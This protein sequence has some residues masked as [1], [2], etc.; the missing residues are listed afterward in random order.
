[1]RWLLVGAP[2]ARADHL[3]GCLGPHDRLRALP[4]VELAAALADEPDVVLIDAGRD[5][6]AA[7]AA[8]ALARR[9]PHPPLVALVVDP[10]DH[11]AL[12]AALG[13]GVVT[14]VAW[15]PGP[16]AMEQLGALLHW[17]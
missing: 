7:V 6:H 17:T 14:L 10:D 4:F 12:D 16:A 13:Q 11:A 5:H 3:S 9:R 15:P 8:L 2:A 1:R